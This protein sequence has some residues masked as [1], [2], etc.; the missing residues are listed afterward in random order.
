MDL[1][2]SE[3]KSK[4]KFYRKTQGGKILA[5]D[6]ETA[7]RLYP[8]DELITLL[9]RGGWNYVTSYGNILDLSNSSHDSQYTVTISEKIR[10]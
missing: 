5:L 10:D 1:R 3:V 7:L 6:I 9:K 8:F 4:S 2:N